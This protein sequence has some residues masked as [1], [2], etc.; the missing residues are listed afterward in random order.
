MKRLFYLIVLLFASGYVSMA[1]ALD[2]GDLLRISVYGNSD[3]TTETRV[4]K[5]GTVRFPLIGEVDVLNAAIPEVERRIAQ[6]L[7][8]KNVLRDPQVNIVI[9]QHGAKVSVLGYVNQPGQYS[10]TES[11]NNVMDFI[12]LAG[13]ISIDG[14]YDITVVSHG[15]GDA[16]KHTIDVDGM[17]GD[18][19]MDRNVH[20]VHGD[21]IYVPQAPQYYIYGEVNRAGAYRLKRN[22]SV[23]QALATAGGISARGSEKGLQIRRSTGEKTKSFDVRLTDAVQVDDVIFVKESLF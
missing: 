12:A 7:S 19:D 3:L 10:I 17:L 16:K 21:I 9:M 2:P 15:S 13:G 14:S 23:A 8:R 18:L 5:D 11:A 22:M 6:G 20:L 4:S 1:A